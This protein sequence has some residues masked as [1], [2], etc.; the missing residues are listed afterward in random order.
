MAELPWLAAGL[1]V[2]LL[3]YGSQ[4]GFSGQC[5]VVRRKVW[6]AAGAFV[7]SNSRRNESDI[8]CLTPNARAVRGRWPPI[9]IV[10]TSGLVDVG[11]KDL[12]EGGRFLAKPYS[13][14]THRCA[15]R[16]DRRKAGWRAGDFCAALAGVCVTTIRQFRQ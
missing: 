2:P 15:A 3:F 8:P 5:T 12:P 4:D 16:I 9:K 7:A 1:Y 6:T 13:Q 14:R 11:E 10:A